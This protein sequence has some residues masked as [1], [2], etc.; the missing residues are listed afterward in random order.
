MGKEFIRIGGAREHNLKNL[1]LEIPRD[2]LVVITGLSGSGKSSLAFDT[3][4]AEGQRKYVES[5]SAYARQFLDQMQKPDV[6]YIEGLSPSIAIEQSRSGMNPRSTVATTTEIYDYLRLLYANVGQPHCPDTGVPIVPQTTSDIVDKILALP[7]KTRV[8]LLAPV[9]QRS[10]GRVPRRRGAARSRRLR[11]RAR[12]RR[13]RRTRRQHPREARPE[14]E[15]QHRRDRGPARHRRQNPRPPERFGRDRAQVGR[16]PACSCCINR[17]T[18]RRLRIGPRRCTRI[19]T[20]VRAPARVSRRSRRNIFPSTRR[21]VRVRSV[22]ASARK[23]CSTRRWWC[24]SLTSR[25][26]TARFCRGDAAASG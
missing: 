10:E 19:A 3:I 5:L 21:A 15:A 22:T 17:P 7:P 12:G 14:G 6:D 2:K 11:A 18:R 24:R 9:I 23:W 8:M 13:T 26:T 25:S 16:R 20:T 1:T 4:Y